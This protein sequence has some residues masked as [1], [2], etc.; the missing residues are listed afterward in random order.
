MIIGAELLKSTMEYIVDT[1]EQ[2]KAL[3]EE[4]KK[5]KEW[6]RESN[7][8]RLKREFSKNPKKLRGID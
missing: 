3:I 2:A 7:R 4:E 5:S 6:R 8:K 1:E